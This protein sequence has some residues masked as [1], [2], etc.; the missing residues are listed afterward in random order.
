VSPPSPAEIAAT[1]QQTTAQQWI[2]NWVSAYQQN[3]QKATKTQHF[4]AENAA[5]SGFVQTSESCQKPGLAG[6]MTPATKVSG[7]TLIH[8]GQMLTRECPL[9]AHLGPSGAPLSANRPF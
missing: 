1:E 8:A 2:S 3:P 9:R 5:S 4:I 7:D 6:V